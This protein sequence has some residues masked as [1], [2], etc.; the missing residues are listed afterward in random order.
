MLRVQ[1]LHCD[2]AR[3]DVR[4]MNSTLLSVNAVLF[5]VPLL[6][7]RYCWAFPAAAATLVE[8]AEAAAEELVEVAERAQ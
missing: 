1:E 2:E 8:L 5:N 7:A 6:V 3:F 4:N